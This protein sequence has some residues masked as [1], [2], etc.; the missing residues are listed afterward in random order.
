MGLWDGGLAIFFG[1]QNSVYGAH[2]SDLGASTRGPYLRT[3]RRAQPAPSKALHSRG[4]GSLSRRWPR[5]QATRET[6]NARA[7]AGDQLRKLVSKVTRSREKTQKGGNGISQNIRCALNDFRPQK[8]SCEDEN[9]V[10]C[11]GQD[12]QR[13][14]AQQLVQLS[15][16]GGGRSRSAAQGSGMGVAEGRG[17]RGRLSLF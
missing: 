8:T 17:H 16:G 5:F 2:N 4:L 9:R 3:R 13:T 1:P 12:G 14:T 10:R 7:T 11:R 6:T 15:V